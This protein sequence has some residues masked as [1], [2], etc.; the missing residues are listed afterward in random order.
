[1]KLQLIAVL[2]LLMKTAEEKRTPDTDEHV[3]EK[4]TNGVA[5][6]MPQGTTA[7]C[8]AWTNITSGATRMVDC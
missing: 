4:A 7:L 3:K 5:Q 1:M 6:L 8:G 2:F